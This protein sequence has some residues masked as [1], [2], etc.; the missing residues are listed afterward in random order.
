MHIRFT[1][2]IQP[3]AIFFDAVKAA[4]YFNSPNIYVI[5]VAKSNC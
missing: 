3:Y 1:V 5:K 2:Y 4:N